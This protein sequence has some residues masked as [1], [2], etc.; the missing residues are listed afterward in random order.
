MSNT[1]T[2]KYDELLGKIIKISDHASIRHSDVFF[3]QPYF[4]PNLA[5]D[6]NPEGQWV[7]SKS[8]KARIMKEKGLIES[9][10]RIHGCRSTSLR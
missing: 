5:D 8:E 7:S 6:K 10:D 4:E 1:G 9:G 2:Y 3:R